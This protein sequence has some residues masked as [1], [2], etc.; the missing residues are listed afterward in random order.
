ML[1]PL[2]RTL[3]R[4]RAWPELW[5]A[6]ARRIV[7]VVEGEMDYLTLATAYAEGLATAPAVIGIVSGS[8][9]ILAH[10]PSCEVIVTT[11]TTRKARS[12]VLRSRVC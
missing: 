7:H 9:P 10:L 11:Q 12:T 4:Y 5:P 6:E 1:C 3:F 2:A 8:A